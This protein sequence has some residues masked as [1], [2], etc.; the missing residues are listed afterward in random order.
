MDATI[1]EAKSIAAYR[2]VQ[3]YFISSYAS[4]DDAASVANNS[5]LIHSVIYP[6]YFVENEH[7]GLMPAATPYCDTPRPT[8]DYVDAFVS[9]LQSDREDK[10]IATVGK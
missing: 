5:E 3:I 1:E 6:K 8:V 7:G 9:C 2:Q 10:L 4:P